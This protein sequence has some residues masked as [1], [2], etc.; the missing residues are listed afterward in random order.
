MINGYGTLTEIS[1]IRMIDINTEPSSKYIKIAA[2]FEAGIDAETCGNS[3]GIYLDIVHSSTFMD[4]G[5]VVWSYVADVRGSDGLG[6]NFS[7]KKRVTIRLV[8]QDG[9]WTSGR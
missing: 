1:Y 2:C 6:G 9:G 3:P 7:E 5:D 4:H 8:K